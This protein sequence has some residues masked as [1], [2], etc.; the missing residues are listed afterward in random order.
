MTLYDDTNCDCC[1]D[2]GCGRCD[3]D[4]IIAELAVKRAES[5]KRDPD[6]IRAGS[7]AT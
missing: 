3:P 5:A 1:A 4:L 6:L 2:R 7:M